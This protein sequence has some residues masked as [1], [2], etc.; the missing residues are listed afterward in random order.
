MGW[1]RRDLADHLKELRKHHNLT[2]G[3]L[4]VALGV[5][6]FSVVRAENGAGGMPQRQFFRALL[7][8]P[9]DPLSNRTQQFIDW[10][11]RPPSSPRTKKQRAAAAEE[12]VGMGW[13]RKELA[14]HIKLLRTYFDMTQA[15]FASRLKVSERT[16]RNAESAASR[17]VPSR[18]F[19]RSL[20]TLPESPHTAATQDLL[21]RG[22]SR[23]IRRRRRKS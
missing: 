2:Q 12:T 20:L 15:A 11:L 4:A 17:Y 18:S 1:M 5:S 13:V 7:S 21:R 23:D 22:L 8:L 9:K 14:G 19:L 16:V 3:D 6:R 10:G